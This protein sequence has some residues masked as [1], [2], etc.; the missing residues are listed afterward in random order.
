VTDAVRE[1]LQAAD[2]RAV[3]WPRGF[4]RE[5]AIKRVAT[6]KP[7]LE[8]I[9]GCAFELDN[10]VEDATFFADL[11][12]Y[13]LFEKVVLGFIQPQ[14]FMLSVFTVR[15]SSFGFLFT[16]VSAYEPRDPERL[17][18]DVEAELVRTVSEAG[19]FYVPEEALHTPYTGTHRRFVG[20]TWW[21]RFFDYVGAE[22]A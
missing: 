18:E 4:D 10:S 7:E 11:S 14:Q 20:S 3:L 13:R 6:L 21:A 17:P 15:F 9:A 1:R 22:R 12:I 8:R 5:A 16:A 19:F 2:H